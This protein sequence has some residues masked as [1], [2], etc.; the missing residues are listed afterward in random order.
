MEGV[1]T[2]PFF[3]CAFAKLSIGPMLNRGSLQMHHTVDTPDE[4]LGTECVLGLAN[5]G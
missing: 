2:S 5:L 1:S 3:S 4:A